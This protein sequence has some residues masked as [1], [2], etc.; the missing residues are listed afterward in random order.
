MLPQK[1]SA[2]TLAVVDERIISNVGVVVFSDFLVT[3]DAGKS[4]Y[5]AKHL[6]EVLEDTYRRPVIYACV[7]HYHPD[8]TAG[9]SAFKDVGLVGC[10]RAAE[11]MRDLPDWCLAEL[12][13][14][15]QDEP[16]GD[17]MP[18][19]IEVVVPTLLFDE[20]IVIAGDKTLELRRCGGHSDCSI[21]GYVPEEKVLFAGD[22]VL[23]DEFPFAG[24]ATA[25]PEVWIATLKKWEALDV[26]H[27]VAGHGPVAGPE[28]ISRQLEFLEALKAGTLDAIAAGKEASA[29][30]TPDMFPVKEGKAWFVEATKQRWHEYYSGRRS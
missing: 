23:V 12:A 18:G 8:H 10:I 20:S 27:V 19:E 22:L 16:G 2:G 9:L 4:P 11:K 1:V 7:T 28:A 24:D 3:M 6:R 26:E 14:W 25:D 30:L 15:S 29:I 21:Y 13:H 17:G 5:A